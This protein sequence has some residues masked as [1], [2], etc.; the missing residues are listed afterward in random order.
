MPD[1][2]PCG[3]EGHSGASDRD[4]TAPLL[5]RCYP[6]TRQ[7][8]KEARDGVMRAWLAILQE[9]YPGVVWVPVENDERP[10]EGPLE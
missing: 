4:E 6:R 9:R 2:N 7:L 10:P 5:P 1:T 3:L 8:P